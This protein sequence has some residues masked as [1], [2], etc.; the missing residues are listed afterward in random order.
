MTELWAWAMLGVLAAL[1]IYQQWRMFHMG[2]HAAKREELF[3]II[4]ENAADMIALVDM[5]G[6]RLYNSPAYKRFLGYSPAELSE[7]SAFEQIHPDDRFRVLDAAR[8]ARSTGGGRDL[9]YRIRHK[10][11]SWRIF[12]SRAST[13]RDK[14]GEVAKL[15]I[16][17]RDVT[18]RRRAEEQIEHNAFHDTLTGLPNRRLFLDRLEGLFARSLRH[19]QRRYALLLI[20]LDNF[21]NFNDT[22]GYAAADE[23]LGEIARRLGA[24]LRQ[25]DTIS[26]TEARAG[27]IVLSRLGGDEF[28][29]LLDG[30][31]DPSD[32]LR[33]AKRIQ[34]VVAEP[35]KLVGG[36]AQISASIG[37]ALSPPAEERRQTPGR[38]ED[39]LREAETA[40]HRAK[41]LGGAR[42]E[43]FDE[44]LH[45]QAVRRLTLE[46]DLYVALERREFRVYYLPI[47]QLETRRIVGFEALL[48]W[49][50]P[51]QGLI[52]P[53]NFLAAAEDRGL[54]VRI[55][56]WELGEVC[57]TLHAWRGD[58]ATAKAN[59]TVNIS[60]RQF[61]DEK[62]TRHV[63]SLL[64]ETGAARSQ[65]QLEITEDIAAADAR[66]TA[67]AL[68]E[69]R[70]AG[71]GVILD[72]F[73]TGHSSLLAL[74]KLPI[75]ALKI[76]RSLVTEM[77]ADRA[78]H[79]IVE[80][81]LM[82]AGRMGLR[83]IAEGVE[84]LK[85]LERLRELGCGLGQGFLFSQ[86]V[87][88]RGAEELLRRQ[89][90]RKGAVAGR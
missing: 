56:Q 3:R 58:E 25:A 62:L 90:T 73:G 81:I 71:I 67:A 2:Q 79:D 89:E 59:I 30:V 70:H 37:I 34:E 26:R 83:V 86:P 13:L 23:A 50:H 77:L 48:R 84:N 41:A 24:C 75:E 66:R 32:A 5:K 17:N 11:G 20:D 57:R 54:M 72:D 49:E 55:G 68:G 46:S 40:M 19:R 76:D 38:A 36:E 39:L 69:L 6:H 60:E 44:A 51:Q 16:V 31:G 82:L 35:M 28:T 15:V 33:V 87:D 12:E 45:S 43:I 42:A 8:E 22:A 18:E 14:N 27:D 74:R 61:H 1:V 64:A 88:G 10:D 47:V 52:S 63:E 80:L 4:T 21:K 9:E 78:A 7:T 85:Q 53:Y 65:L 29:V